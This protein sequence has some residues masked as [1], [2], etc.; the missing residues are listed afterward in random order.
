MEFQLSWFADPVFYGEYPPYMV[1]RLGS[2]LPSFTQDESDLL[3][4]TAPKW[5]ALNHYSTN[6]AADPYSALNLTGDDLEEAVRADL[7]KSSSTWVKY[8][9]Y[10][11]IK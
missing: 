10:N 4:R 9:S 11:K 3:K 2:R 8:A 6:F 7:N 1:E 5:F